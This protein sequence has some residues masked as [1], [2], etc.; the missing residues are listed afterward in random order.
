MSIKIELLNTLHPKLNFQKVGVIN[1]ISR[2]SAKINGFSIDIFEKK[3]GFGMEF[4]SRTTDEKKA[5][6]EQMERLNMALKRKD[7]VYYP[8][9]R[10]LT[11]EK[12][13]MRNR[14]IILFELATADSRD[15]LNSNT[16]LFVKGNN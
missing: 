4:R 10:N 12:E 6:L 2:Y 3:N 13:E 15:H 14:L 9:P 5:L 7:F 1:E 16:L 8:W 11:L